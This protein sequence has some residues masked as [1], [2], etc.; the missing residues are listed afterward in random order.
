M[1]RNSPHAKV[2][3]IEPTE[4]PV[5]PPEAP[6]SDALRDCALEISEANGLLE[7]SCKGVLV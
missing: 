6:V 3:I 4:V 5:E 1:G 7:L 2:L